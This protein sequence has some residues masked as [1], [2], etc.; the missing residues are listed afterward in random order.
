MHSVTVVCDVGPIVNLSGAE[1]QCQGSVIDGLSAMLDQKL[2][3]RN[4]RVAQTNFDRYRLLRM[5]LDPRIDV[6][7]IESDFAP[8]GLGEP[9]LPPVAPAICNAVFSASG[10]RIR[11]LPISAEGY[12]F[13][14]G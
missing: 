12:R 6:H 8:S 1:S 2:D 7:F 5:G 4:G 3:Y 13:T 14:K 11:R 9:A 10:R